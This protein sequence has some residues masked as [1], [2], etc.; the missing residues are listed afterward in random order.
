MLARFR[1]PPK[2][3]Q[4]PPPVVGHSTVSPV[5]LATRTGSSG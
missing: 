1:K 5:Q 3:G 2:R 4:A